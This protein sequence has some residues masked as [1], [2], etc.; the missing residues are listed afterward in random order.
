MEIVSPPCQ[1]ALHSHAPQD[2]NR[3]EYEDRPQACDGVISTTMKTISMTKMIEDDE[4]CD[5]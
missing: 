2:W 1:A 3:L 5:V 4:E